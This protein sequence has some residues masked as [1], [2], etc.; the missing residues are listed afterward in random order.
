[1]NK[2]LLNLCIPKK[3]GSLNRVRQRFQEIFLIKE[4]LMLLCI[5]ID[6]GLSDSTQDSAQ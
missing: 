5:P 2:C 3:I 1:M 6:L 4:D